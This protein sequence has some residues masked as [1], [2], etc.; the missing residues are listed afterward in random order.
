MPHLHKTCLPKACEIVNTLKFHPLIKL[1]EKVKR[2]FV[3]G[4]FAHGTNRN[5]S[6]I[7]VLLEVRAKKNI[8]KQEL[9]NKYRTKIVKHFIKNNICSDDSVH[10]QWNCHRIDVY[11][12]YDADNDPSIKMEL[13]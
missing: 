12:T 3:V 4:S 1:K 9:E 8:T 11:F 7:D 5:D 13:Q 2:V 10:P 6:D